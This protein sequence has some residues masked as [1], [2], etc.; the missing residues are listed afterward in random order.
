MFT[1]QIDTENMK[2]IEQ[3]STYLTNSHNNVLNIHSKCLFSQ[4]SAKKNF[5]YFFPFITIF[6]VTTLL[7]LFSFIYVVVDHDILKKTQG[8]SQRGP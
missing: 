3:T 8:Y 6:Q 7:K 1:P 5:D 2:Q 4:I